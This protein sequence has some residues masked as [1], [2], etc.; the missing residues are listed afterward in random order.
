MF[1]AYEVVPGNSPSEKGDDGT[2]RPARVA[3]P[4]LL[5]V[6]SDVRHSW[7]ADCVGGESPP[8]ERNQLNPKRELNNHPVLA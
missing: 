7:N 4:V 5:P 3:I 6:V 1:G 2:M 8:M